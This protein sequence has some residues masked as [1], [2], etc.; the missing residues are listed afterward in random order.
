MKFKKK[1][2][3]NLLL[4]NF[5]SVDWISR[6]N[7]DTEYMYYSWCM[8]STDIVKWRKNE[9]LWKFWKKGDSREKG[10]GGKEVIIYILHSFKCYLHEN[11]DLIIIFFT[12]LQNFLFKTI[13]FSKY[14]HCSSFR[15]FWYFCSGF[16]FVYIYRKLMIANVHFYVSKSR[17]DKIIY[18]TSYLLSCNDSIYSIY[19]PNIFFDIGQL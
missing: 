2:S 1:I 14:Y 4:Y 9:W 15:L 11:L 8:T 12:L 17:I 18:L 6:K 5:M 13:Y 3:I 7:V 19:R 16:F 10:G